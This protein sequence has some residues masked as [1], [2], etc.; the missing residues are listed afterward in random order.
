M[1]NEKAMYWLAVGVVALGVNS[2]FQDREVQWTQKLAD[3][4]AAAVE[5]I[6]ERGLDTLAMAETVLGRNPAE[7][8]RLQAALGRLQAKTA[9]VQAALARQQAARDRMQ[10]QLDRVEAQRLR[11]D[12]KYV[13]ERSADPKY[14]LH[15]K[16][17]CP[18]KIRVRVPDVQ[19]DVQPVAQWQD[20]SSSR[21]WENLKGMENLRGMESLRSLESLR[22]LPNASDFDFS[23]MDLNIPQPQVRVESGNGPI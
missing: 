9:R 5:R 1:A 11:I 21:P 23:S 22:N 19:V 18:R 8:T 14:I 16:D 6:A 7:S 13:I 17:T 2:A 12:Q 15:L 10:A 3:H 4:S 20:W